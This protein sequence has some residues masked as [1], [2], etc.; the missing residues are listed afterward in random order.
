ME[1]Y[2]IFIRDDELGEVHG[3]NRNQKI[4]TKCNNCNMIMAYL[5]EFEKD[6]GKEFRK[7]FGKEYGVKVSSKSHEKT[8]KTRQIE[9]NKSHCL[10]VSLM[11]SWILFCTVYKFLQY[12][13][14][15]MTLYQMI[16]YQ[17]LVY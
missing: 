4:P 11:M 1:S 10:M 12:L 14:Y 3:R 9:K 2:D 7:E 15:Q 8:K 5:M 17:F 6:V 16:L 13:V